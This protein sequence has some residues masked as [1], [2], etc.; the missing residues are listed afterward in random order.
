MLAGLWPVAPLVLVI[1]S[2]VGR[3]CWWSLPSTSSSSSS[4]NDV[5]PDARP[6]RIR[7]II[8]TSSVSFRNWTNKQINKSWI[9]S[10]AIRL[11][12]HDSLVAG[13]VVISTV[14]M[15]GAGGS[16]TSAASSQTTESKWFLIVIQFL[17]ECLIWNEWT[18]SLQQRR[19]FL[20]ISWLSG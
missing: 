17:F 8:F 4:S 10:S 2:D 18:K 16:T 14:I 12:S 9:F 20:F 3:P 19:L 6:H 11:I 15:T 13:R 5:R 1:G 7:L